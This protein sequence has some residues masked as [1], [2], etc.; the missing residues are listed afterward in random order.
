MLKYIFSS[1]VCMHLVLSHYCSAEDCRYH[2]LLPGS[3]YIDNGSLSD[4]NLPCTIE[5]CSNAEFTCV[6]NGTGQDFSYLVFY[7]NSIKTN[8]ERLNCT[9]RRTSWILYNNFTALFNVCLINEATCNILT[10]NLINCALNSFSTTHAS[11]SASTAFSVVTTTKITTSLASSPPP[12]SSLSTSSTRVTTTEWVKATSLE[13]AKTT[14]NNFSASR[15]KNASQSLQPDISTIHVSS[16]SDTQEAKENKKLI[17]G[18]PVAFGIAFLILTLVFIVAFV[19]YTR[20]KSR[21]GKKTNALNTQLNLRSSQISILAITDADSQGYTVNYANHQAENKTQNDGLSVYTN[22]NSLSSSYSKSIDT[23]ED[24]NFT[25][26]MT[27]SEPLLVQYSMVKKTHNN[28]GTP[29]SAGHASVQPGYTSNNL[30]GNSRS[31][32][33]TENDTTNHEKKTE[34]QTQV[35]YS[36]LFEVSGESS[37]EYAEVPIVKQTDKQSVH[38]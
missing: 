17:I 36:K 33:L 19:R 11:T 28:V 26:T 12:L 31:M 6:Y 14:P 32:L 8:S 29:G 10:R 3:C 20:N 25:R 2:L 22:E 30:Y 35:N 7:C 1:L 5:T 4:V 24:V 16:H 9:F 18:L 21:A 37:S 38:L 15:T 23:P 27:H 13:S 34:S